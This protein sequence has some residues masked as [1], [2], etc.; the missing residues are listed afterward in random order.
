MLPC[1]IFMHVVQP[2]WPGAKVG[3]GLPISKSYSLR[4]KADAD[5]KL[6]NTVQPNY[7]SSADE[8]GRSV[9]LGN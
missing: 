4:A 7:K 1:A 6:Q 9:E 3:G 8:L 5:T 2:L